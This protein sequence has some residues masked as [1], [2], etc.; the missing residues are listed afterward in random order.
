MECIILQVPCLYLQIYFLPFVCPRHW[1][2]LKIKDVEL[3]LL[4]FKTGSLV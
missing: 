1:S 4:K 2:S 3:L